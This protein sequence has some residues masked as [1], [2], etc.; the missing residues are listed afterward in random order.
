MKSRTSALALT[1]CAALVV[2]SG[3]A[4]AT[5]HP[6]GS[7]E[8]HRIKTVE[9]SATNTVIVN[10]VAGLAV[11]VVVAPGEKYITHVFGD[12]KAWAFA[13][14]GNNYFI[15]PTSNE[16]ADTNLVI[17]TNR[18]TYNILLRAISSYTTKGPDGKPVKHLIHVP[19]TMKV[20][21]V[22]V[23]YQY[24]HTEARRSA[25]AL[26]QQQ[27]AASL[28]AWKHN[29]PVNAR[30]VMSNDPGSQEIQPLNVWDNYR[31]TFFRFPAN[32]TLPTIFAVGPDG[33]EGIA[34]VSIE[35][36]NHNII[37][38]HSVARQWRIRYGKKVVGVV[39]NGYNPSWGANPS[40]TDSPDVRRVIDQKQGD[41]P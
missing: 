41:T 2:G 32:A 37:V 38:A 19:W 14:V 25:A 18:H 16:F 20:A 6:K 4:H 30:Y 10:A 5:S 7:P 15:K 17:V 9:Y 27:I 22:Q 1:F 21:T 8:D 36:K 12:P 13:H 26:E 31:F 39:D 24:P 11:H 40:G 3:V 23:T 29:G 33:K 34:N 28:Q 35:G